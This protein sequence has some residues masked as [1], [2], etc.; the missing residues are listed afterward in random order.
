M[1]NA[2]RGPA[3]VE[4]DY[5]ECVDEMRAFV[6]GGLPGVQRLGRVWHSILVA[7]GVERCSYAEVMARAGV[8]FRFGTLRVI[9]GSQE[10]NDDYSALVLC[11][12]EDTL[13]GGWNATTSEEP[14]AETSDEPYADSA[15]D[16]HAPEKQLSVV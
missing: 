5:T 15:A 14:S 11:E 10:D 6:R 7:Y 16:A 9:Q 12:D 1:K 3:R 8:D 4:H 13:V 2:K